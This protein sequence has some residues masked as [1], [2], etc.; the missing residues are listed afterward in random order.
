MKKIFSILSCLC[1]LSMTACSLKQN[2]VT[3]SQS[4]AADSAKN[5]KQDPKIESLQLT[6]NRILSLEKGLSA[7][8]FEGDDGF[9]AFLE[10]G[11]AASDA[12]VLAFL[13]AYFLTGTSGLDFQV[14]GCGCSSL[15][16]ANENGDGYYFGRNFDWNRCE[17]LI[18]VSSPRKG[19][20]SI[21]TV[22]T[23]FIKQAAHI[24]LPDSVLKTAALYAPLDG[25]NEKG[26]CASVNMIQDHATIKQQT[27]KAGLTT[28]TVIRL[29][30]NQ[31]ATVDEALALLESYDVHASFGYMVHFAIADAAGNAVDV[32]YIDGQMSV[33]PTPILTNFYLTEGEK[34]GIGTAQSHTR[35]AI[36]EERREQ[37]PAM[38]S[39]E[40]CDSLSAVSKG[41]FGEFEST[42][43]SVVFDQKNCTA[44]YFHRENYEKGY[45][46]GLE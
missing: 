17:A 16:V 23:D 14:R 10:Q 31:A 42:E 25:M 8:V 21:S 33:I 1:L 37:F 3:G 26:L 46:I 41:N 24:P 15:S 2:G 11:G 38:T 45:R 18:L 27:G 30:L 4:A 5:A 32:E 6:G 43:W 28:T 20:R 44:V 29:L 12:E 9:E 40:V 7:A 34:Y 19:Y 39:Q 13:K 36:L 35:F 22:N